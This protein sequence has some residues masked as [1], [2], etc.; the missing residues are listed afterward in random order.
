MQALVLSDVLG[1]QPNLHLQLMLAEA[2]L[3]PSEIVDSLLG[4]YVFSLLR[5]VF[6]II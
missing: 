5:P 6:F 2:S 4:T 3:S 1:A